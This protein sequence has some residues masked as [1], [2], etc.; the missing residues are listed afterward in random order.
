MVAAH[1]L[2]GGV[3]N[4]GTLVG[5]S[6]SLGHGT[7]EHAP[8]AAGGNL[9]EFLDIDVHQ[10]ARRIVF[11]A[12]DH[13]PGA[14]I[15]ACVPRQLASHSEVFTMSAHHAVTNVH[16]QYSGRRRIQRRRL[17]HRMPQRGY[18]SR[19]SYTARVSPGPLKSVITDTP[20]W[21]GHRECW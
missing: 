12:A 18:G 5:L 21:N 13:R 9:S 20:R 11:I 16:G 6:I 14:R 2:A 10:I 4:T 15:S 17:G 8:A 19:S 1:R 7:P 3:E